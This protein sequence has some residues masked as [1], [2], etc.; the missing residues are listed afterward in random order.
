MLSEGEQEDDIEVVK[1]DD[2]AKMVTFNNHGVM[3]DVP[4][5]NTPSGGASG[6]GPAPAKPPPGFPNFPTFRPN[7]A[8]GGAAGGAFNTFGGGANP[9]A[10][11]NP[12]GNPG[13]NFNSGA[14]GGAPVFG[15]GYGGNSGNANPQAVA[16]L[17]PDQQM[18]MITAQHLKAQQEGS[19]MAPLFPPTPLD[20]EAGITQDSGNGGS[21]PAP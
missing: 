16:V 5:A 7:A 6:G 4:L 1:I 10:G 2:K 8:P 15:S 12:G 18:L 14:S 17:P 3:Q 19:P 20:R 11:R 9:F 13:N 21:P